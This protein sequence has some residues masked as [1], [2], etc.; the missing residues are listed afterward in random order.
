MSR[1][2]PPTHTAT[3]VLSTGRCGTQ[4]IA[5]ALGDAFPHL[6]HVTHEPIH[7]GYEPRNARAAK[8]VPAVVT[9][10]LDRIEEI[11][12]NQSYL[13]CG[14]PAWSSL[15][16]IAARFPGRFRIIHLT[17]HPVPCSYSW[18]THGAFQTPLLPHLPPKDLLV[19]TDPGVLYPGY[20]PHWETL[21]P[22]EK[23][24]YYWCEVNG[25]ALRL[26]TELGVPWLRLRSE[27]L[28]KG[29]GLAAMLAFL[30][31]PTDTGKIPPHGEVVDRF[32]YLS[33]IWTEWQTILS[34]PRALQI[35]GELGYN[36]DGIDESALKRRYLGTVC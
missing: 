10:H 22:Y 14:H 36:F 17:R 31:L 12:E 29:D 24:I 25:F 32:Q 19:P 23:C 13:E 35:A 28:F 6:L 34:H 33:G 5:S 20:S 18:L 1:T 15:P 27:D 9:K 11:L 3:F 8:A 2:D 26:E 16:A 4:W 30:D 7:N 21:S